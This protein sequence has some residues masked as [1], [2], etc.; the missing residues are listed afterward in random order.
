MLKKNAKPGKKEP[1]PPKVKISGLRELCPEK[2]H[3]NLGNK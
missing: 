2:N 3:Y 1:Q